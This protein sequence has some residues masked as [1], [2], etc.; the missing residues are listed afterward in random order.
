MDSLY[1]VYDYIDRDHFG[2]AGGCIVYSSRDGLIIL[3]LIISLWSCCWVY[4]DGM[5]STSFSCV[6]LIWHCC[7]VCVSSPRADDLFGTVYLQWHYINLI[8]SAELHATCV[9]SCCWTISVT[10]CVL[11]ALCWVACFGRQLACRPFLF[12]GMWCRSLTPQSY[13]VRDATRW[14]WLLCKILAVLCCV[15]WFLS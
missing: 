15:M 10:L 2:P 1:H 3:I 9:S 5:D 7:V 13:D 6:D 11:D 4:S 8:R 12:Q 14:P